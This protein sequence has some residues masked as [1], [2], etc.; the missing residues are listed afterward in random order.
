MRRLFAAFPAFAAICASLGAAAQTGEPAAIVE[1]ATVDTGLA[2]MDYLEVGR[3]LILPPGRTILIGYLSSC[4]RERIAGGTV[5]IGLAR[6]TVSGGEVSRDHVA[7]AGTVVEVS[8]ATA[9]SGV[10]VFRKP[11][12]ASGDANLPV[13]HSQQPIFRLPGPGLVRLQRLDVSEPTLEMIATGRALDL[14]M[15][16]VVLSPGGV[17]RAE[18]HGSAMEFT[19]ASDARPGKVALLSRLIAF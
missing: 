10:I 14:A 2:P 17:Y 1:E 4:V 9:E 16:G 15:T 3:T 19:V 18:A 7:C 5:V 12:G 8:P 6:S 11:V 13:I